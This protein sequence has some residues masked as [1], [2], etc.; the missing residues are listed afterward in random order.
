MT[1]NKFKH[2]LT[3][4]MIT[5]LVVASSCSKI[6]KFDDTNQNPGATGSPSTPGLLTNVLS[7]LAGVTWDAGGYTTIAGLY[8]QYFSETQYTEVS[9]YTKSNPNWDGT[10]AGSLFDL[11]NIINYNSDPETAALAEGIGNGSNNNQIAVARILKTYIFSSLSDGYGD[12]PYSGALKGDNGIVAFDKQQDL[13]NSFFSELSQAVAQIEDDKLG[14][15]GDILFDG[16]MSKWKKFAN[17]IH[18][19]LALNLSKVDPATGAAEFN[20][21][22]DPANGG[23]I[24]EGENIQ[25]VFPGGNF[26]N[27]IYNYYNITQRLDYGVSETMVDWLNNHNDYRYFY[28]GTVAS[29]GSVIG[30]P[31]GLTR[32]DAVAFANANTQWA[33]L[34]AGADSKDTDPFNI[35]TSG[36]VF[37]ARAEAAQLGWTTEDAAAMYATGIEESW[38][39]WM[40]ADYDASAYADYMAQ[41]TIDL[42]TGSELEKIATQEWV[43]H[44]PAG[45]RGWSVW[46]RT[47]FPALDPAPGSTSHT[48]PRR[49]AYGTNE[50]SYNPTNVKAAAA[51]YD[52]NGENDSQYGRI[53]WDKP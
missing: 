47:G 17:S 16:D 37:L 46:R 48:I 25:L 49:F 23:V 6:D 13:Y 31:Y 4:G 26:P 41:A 44:Y 18:A 10:Y 28:Y 20:K 52:T 12:L 50:Y 3:A 53:W 30:F 40:G 34:L 38:K 7:G 43:T 15:K 32:E 22:I 45:I 51:Q 9:T 2:F 5:S 11:Q 1:F 19:L 42:S 27:P 24:E 21:A 8:A 39:Q 29:S 33:R 35:I 14:P 36:E